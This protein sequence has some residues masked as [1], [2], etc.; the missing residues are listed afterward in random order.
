MKIIKLILFVSCIHFSSHICT[1][2]HRDTLQ[3][4]LETIMTQCDV[5]TFKKQLGVLSHLIAPEK[6]TSIQQELLACAQTIKAY[7]S[8][9]QQAL[10]KKY[11]LSRFHAERSCVWAFLTLAYGTQLLMI[12]DGLGQPADI[13]EYIL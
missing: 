12:K 10:N 3:Y 5:T 6:Y 9:K 11:I 2:S 8:F 4:E 13:I 7:K 1:I